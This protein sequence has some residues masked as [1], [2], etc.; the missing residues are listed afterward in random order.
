MYIMTDGQTDSMAK[1]Q[2]DRQTE[3]SRDSMNRQLHRWKDGQIDRRLSE[4]CN[5]QMDRET[6]GQIGYKINVLR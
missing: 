5:G 2:T 1:R 4:T 6:R 3:M